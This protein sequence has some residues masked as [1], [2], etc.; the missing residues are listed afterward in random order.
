MKALLLSMVLAAGPAL[1]DD[2]SPKQLEFLTKTT[3][4]LER[5]EVLDKVINCPGGSNGPDDEIALMRAASDRAGTIA[6]YIFGDDTAALQ[7]AMKAFMLRLTMADQR[8]REFSGGK[9]WHQNCASLLVP[10]G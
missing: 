2:L 4:L 6:M 1:G 8:A 7:I 10:G 5:Y 3:P 9:D